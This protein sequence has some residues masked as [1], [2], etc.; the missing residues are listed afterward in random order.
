MNRAERRQERMRD[1]MNERA[2]AHRYQADR[3]DDH[4]ID[5]L[6]YQIQMNRVVSDHL[7]QQSRQTAPPMVQTDPSPTHW[8][9]DAVDMMSVSY[10]PRR[11]PIPA[12]QSEPDHRMSWPRWRSS[13]DWRYIAIGQVLEFFHPE[14]GTFHQLDYTHPLHSAPEETISEFLNSRVRPNRDPAIHPEQPFRIEFRNGSVIRVPVDLEPMI[15]RIDIND[16]WGDYTSA[17]PVGIK[18]TAT[19]KCLNCQHVWFG[20]DQECLACGEEDDIFVTIDQL[21]FVEYDRMNTPETE[22]IDDAEEESDTYDEDS[23][24]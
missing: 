10:A 15:H 23:P 22:E 9:G 19:R 20:M 7:E 13:P 12:P 14:S 18:E 1:T 11:N 8:L 2:S 3:A 4:M 16:L 17:R 5:A 21:G 6:R 24:W